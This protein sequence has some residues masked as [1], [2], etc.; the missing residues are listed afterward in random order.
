MCATT[1]IGESPVFELHASKLMLTRLPELS[2]SV[3]IVFFSWI[4]DKVIYCLVVFCEVGRTFRA[5]LLS[6]ANISL[7]L[8][9][10]LCRSVMLLYITHLRNN[11]LNSSTGNG[12]LVLH[13]FARVPFICVFRSP[14]SGFTK[15][16]LS[17][18]ILFIA[19]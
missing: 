8:W 6:K 16:S 15:T 1:S 18:D 13:N 12:L 11:S 5:K 9:L 10:T 17:R 7:R 2:I 3:R 14:G 4:N 19:I